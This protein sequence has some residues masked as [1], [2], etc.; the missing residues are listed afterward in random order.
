MFSLNSVRSLFFV[1]LLTVGC[2]GY[3]TADPDDYVK[4]LNQDDA[5]AIIWHDS[6]HSTD[7]PPAVSW[8]EGDKLD[9]ADGH[10]WVYTYKDDPPV[11][12]AG[13]YSYQHNLA[14]VSWWD[15]AVF[16][17]TALA[18]ELCHAYDYLTN[19]TDDPKHLGPCFTTGGMVDQANERL[20]AHG[21]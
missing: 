19:G 10:G 21:L 17:K 5:T 18:H 16:S 9:C 2:T 3:E 6:F 13:L 15:G 7:L 8:I 4:I 11:C 1:L 20:R 12:V 14:E